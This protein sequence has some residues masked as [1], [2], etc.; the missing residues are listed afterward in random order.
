MYHPEVGRVFFN[1][2]ALLITMLFIFYFCYLPGHRLHDI[3]NNTQVIKQWWLIELEVNM[4]A[5]AISPNEYCKLLTLQKN[6]MMR[7]TQKHNLTGNS[8]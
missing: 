6:K 2:M 4:G 8:N 1:N 3:L 5:C 7:Q